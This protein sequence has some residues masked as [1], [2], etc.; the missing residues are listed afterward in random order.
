MRLKADFQII[1]LDLTDL[2][3]ASKYRSSLKMLS[4]TSSHSSIKEYC[5]CT[6]PPALGA[7]NNLQKCRLIFK[8]LC[9][10]YFWSFYS[11]YSLQL[12][13]IYSLVQ[14]VIDKAEE[15]KQGTYEQ[16][17]QTSGATQFRRRIHIF[18]NQFDNH[19]LTIG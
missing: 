8:I 12:S 5:R 9:C 13:L 7:K 19:P 10:Y 17:F 18:I 16:C 1:R 14:R 6:A 11:V 15:R 4:A 3:P 2:L